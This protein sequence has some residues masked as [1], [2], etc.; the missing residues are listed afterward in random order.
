M[1]LKIL[2]QKFDKEVNH[3][4]LKYFF[5]CISSV[6]SNYSNIV[7]IQFKK[8]S[9][10]L[11]EVID[12]LIKMFAS[13][14]ENYLK[15]NEECFNENKD[16]DEEMIDEKEKEIINNA[17]KNFIMFYDFIK[18]CFDD[19]IDKIDSPNNYTRNLGMYLLNKIIGNIPQLRKYIPIL[20]QMDIS[21]L[22]LIDFFKY[23]KEAKIPLN[24]RQIIYNCN[25]NIKENKINLNQA[26]NKKYILPIFY[27]TKIYSKLDAIFNALTKK[28]GLREA[29]FATLISYS[30]AL[31][32]I[33]NNAPI[34]IEEYIFNNNNNN[35]NN[36]NLCLEVIKA[37]YFNILISYFNYCEISI[38]FKDT[39]SF[40]TKL[41]YLFMEQLL[42][43]KNVEYEFKISV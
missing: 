26:N 25:N 1:L 3:K 42:V 6:T 11:V 24:Y 23:Y 12:Y 9:N 31:I 19:I 14:D 34:L 2:L 4:Y 37:L 43:E 5:K 33:F 7:K 18:Y 40:R 29:K 22:S 15:L 32:N 41:I 20:F 38:Y 10:I 8:G 28:L 21:K 35:G 30:D 17:K 16:K 36:L 13:N 39:D 27:K